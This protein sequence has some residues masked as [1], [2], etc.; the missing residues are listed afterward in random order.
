[1]TELEKYRLAHK[2]LLEKMDSVLA[3]L[4]WEFKIAEDKI[5]NLRPLNLIDRTENYSVLMD[6]PGRS[7]AETLDDAEPLP[8]YY[9]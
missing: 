8:P 2:R 3:E 5:S 9:R 4:K 1:M 6:K 7:N